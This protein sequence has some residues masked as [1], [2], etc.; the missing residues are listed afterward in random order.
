[1]SFVY[2][3]KTP[4]EDHKNDTLNIYC[5]TK[6]IHTS[7]VGATFPDKTERDLIGKYGIIKSTI[8]CPEF[9]ISFAGNNILFAGK[10]F[11][12][13]KELQTFER[14]N[15]VE[16]AYNIHKSVSDKN[17]IEFIISSFE[18]NKLQIDCI[19]NRK[20]YIDCQ[21]A[22]IGS[23]MAHEHF[24]KIRVNNTNDN[25]TAAYEKTHFAFGETVTGCGD[26]S[27]G[28]FPIKVT[29][30]HTESSFAFAYYYKIFDSL[31]K[32]LVMPGKEVIF[33]TSTEDG[34]YSFEIQPISI[35]EVLINIEQINFSIVYSRCLRMSSTSANNN[36]LSSFMLPMLV[37][38]NE[39]GKYKRLR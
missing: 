24:Q 31:K 29:Y 27:V 1:M 30:N 39:N 12:Q 25:K 17:D 19:K 37:I 10:L 22:W 11:N 23:I 15:V 36:N 8:I 5:D 13:L 34:G 16:I 20:T 4:N 7:T 9:C 28:G 6:I 18:N 38:Q 14:N 21:N 32:Q 26:D 35:Y 3:E 2:A 33:N